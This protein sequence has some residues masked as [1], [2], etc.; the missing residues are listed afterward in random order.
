MGYDTVTMRITDGQSVKIQTTDGYIE[1][2]A[3]HRVVMCNYPLR[4]RKKKEKS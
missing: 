4:K 2:E 3:N 1:L